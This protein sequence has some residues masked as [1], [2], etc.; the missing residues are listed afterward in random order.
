MASISVKLLNG[1]DINT[2]LTWFDYS[3]KERSKVGWQDSRT[4]NKL[5]GLQATLEE[6]LEQDED[7]QRDWTE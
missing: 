4:L 6:A 1:T 3:F 2:I 7:Y 5:L